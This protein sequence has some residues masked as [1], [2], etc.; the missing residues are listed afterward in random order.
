[1]LKLAYPT[2][3]W[4]VTQGFGDNPSYYA[5]LG[6]N[7][8]NGLDIGVMTGCL[9]SAAHDGVVLFT[10]QDGSGGETVLLRTT[11]PHDGVYYKTIYVH[12]KTGS[13]KVKPGD[14]VT[15]G[16][17]LAESNN[18]G[19]SAGPHLHFA[20]KP[21]APGEKDWDWY[22]T[23]QNNGY[24][25]AIDPTPFLTGDYAEDIWNLKQQISILK[26][27]IELYKKLFGK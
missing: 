6:I 17:P 8:H 24:K 18:T 3:P 9:V 7:G 21:V 12:L 13:Y 23:E 10:G 4:F 19:W 2:K 14:I 27:L 11:E 16:Q 22:N 5:W 20:L 25:G 1:M 15:T 26:K